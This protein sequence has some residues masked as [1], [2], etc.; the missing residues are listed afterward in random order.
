AKSKQGE[1]FTIEITSPVLAN[2]TDVVI[3][4]GSRIIGEVVEAI[5]SGK[6]PR[7]KGMPK[8]NGKLRTSLSMLQTPDGVSRPLIAT[9]AGEFIASGRGVDRPN[10]E[11]NEPNLGYAGSQSSFD[12]VH[13]TMGKKNQHGKGPQVVDRRQFF[14][15][16]ILG[17]STNKHQHGSQVIRSMVQKGREIYIYGGSPLTVRIDAPFKVAVAPSAGRMSIDVGSGAPSMNGE[18]GD[19]KNFRRFQPASGEDSQ[20]GSQSE[21]GRSTG[22]SK[23]KHKRPALRQ[24]P[25]PEAHLPVF[26]RSPKKDGAFLNEPDPMQDTSAD[27]SAGKSKDRNQ[28]Q[29]QNQDQQEQQGQPEGGD[30]F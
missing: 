3:P 29:D 5:P 26:L 9:I 21:S 8:P 2:G 24:A 18:G 25:D 20:S 13:P 22:S 7:H 30:D 12:A 10:D 27:F 19:L 1:H 15:D 28:N 17:S 14:K 11:I 16:P 6:Q 23:N 4:V